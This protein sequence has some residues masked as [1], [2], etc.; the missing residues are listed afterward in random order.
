MT[1]DIEYTQYCISPTTDKATINF[2]GVERAFASSAREWAERW[3]EL[4]LYQTKGG[5][6][7]L[8]RVGCS[9]LEGEIERRDYM[10]FRNQ[11]RMIDRLDFS[12]LVEDI[13]SQIDVQE[14]RV[15]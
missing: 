13:Y 11:K 6:F 2:E 15:L 7:V 8:E 12:S 14:A 4:T 5:K 3:T 10:V 1:R 9:D